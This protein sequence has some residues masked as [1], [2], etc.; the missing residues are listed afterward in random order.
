MLE[1]LDEELSSSGVNGG[2]DTG[3]GTGSPERD[4]MGFGREFK[5]NP[6]API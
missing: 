5:Y 6:G 2:V 3:T 1:K 4:G